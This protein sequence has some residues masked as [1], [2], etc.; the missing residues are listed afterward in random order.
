M[1]NRDVLEAFEIIQTHVDE[2]GQLNLHPQ[3]QE[4]ELA[5]QEQ[6]LEQEEE[7][8]DGGGEPH[9]CDNPD[10]SNFGPVMV[11]HTYPLDLPLTLFIYHSHTLLIFSVTYTLHHTHQ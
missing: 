7:D 5:A 10:C 2:Y 1:D 11:P 9:D 3:A 8:D 4:Q 6:E